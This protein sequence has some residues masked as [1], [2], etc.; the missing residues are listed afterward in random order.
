MRIA[1]G[2]RPESAWRLR[3]RAGTN[4]AVVPRAAMRSAC[5]ATL[6]AFATSFPHATTEP[7]LHRDNLRLRR[8][9]AGW[10]SEP[11]D[12]EEQRREDAGGGA[13]RGGVA[14]RR[15]NP[16]RQSQRSDPPRRQR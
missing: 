5:I 7:F 11:A 2:N 10:M 1:A 16:G 8:R 14:R 13:R 6:A 3:D 15:E 9:V 4:G 12:G